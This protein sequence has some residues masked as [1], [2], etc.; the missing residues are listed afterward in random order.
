MPIRVWDGDLPEEVATA[1]R[2]QGTLAVDTDTSGLDWTSDILQLIQFSSESTGPVLVRPGS[3]RPREITSLLEDPAV[4]K[5][6]HFAPFDLRFIRS[7]W[8][9]SAA[10]VRCTKTASK[11]LNPDAPASSHS[12]Q[13]LLLHK[14]GVKINKG[15]VRVGDWGASDLTVEQLEYAAAD[16]THLLELH[17]K[18]DAELRDARLSGLY[19]EICR[20][21]PTDAE[22]RVGRFP[23]PLTY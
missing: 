21:L 3:T 22:L 8:D 6:F 18:L 2:A 1:L 5:V 16:V 13:A 12:L 9:I 20:Y 11:L 19:R 15:S 7:A 23:D 17:D 10:S 14:L 4:D